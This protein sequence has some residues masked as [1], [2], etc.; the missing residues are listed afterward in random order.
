MACNDVSS[1]Q[2]RIETNL[3]CCIPGD[4]F[5][6]AL[7]SLTGEEVVL[8][9]VQE[10]VVVQQGR[11]KVKLP[12]LPL[13][14]FPFDIPETKGK[15]LTLNASVL[16]GI[17]YCLAFSGNDPTHPAQMGVTLAPDFDDGIAAFSTDNYTVSKYQINSTIELP[18]D[19]P[20]ILPVFFCQQL[21]NLSKVFPKE[22]IQLFP[23]SEHLIAELGN[24]AVLYTKVAVDAEPMD[25]QRVLDKHLGESDDYI[26]SLCSIP[27]GFDAAVDRALMVA[28]NEVDKATTLTV[29]KGKLKM[30]TTSSTAESNDTFS[31]DC[32]DIE[33]RVDPMLTAR[34]LKLHSKFSLQEKCLVF[35]NEAGC[36]HMMAY[37]A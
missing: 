10:A 29:V 12:I 21:L 11:S 4:L 36:L 3:D 17:E 35:S 28:S 18:G 20:I 24:E 30:E 19:V 23:T 27:D 1:I 33:V 8:S 14:S 2:A 25:F 26:D 34:A 37:L 22:K 32:D 31:L 6:K 7:G 5:L 13:D 15:G 16:N 9:L